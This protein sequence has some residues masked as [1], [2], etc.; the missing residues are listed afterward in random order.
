M[1]IWSYILFGVHYIM[2]P[3]STSRYDPQR[4]DPKRFIPKLKLSE[5][6]L[7]RTK[8]TRRSKSIHVVWM[9]PFLFRLRCDDD[10]SNSA[11]QQTA[12]PATYH[13]N[14]SATVALSFR[15]PE[16]HTLLQ[17]R[18]GGVMFVNK[19]P[20]IFEKCNSNYAHTYH[21]LLDIYLVVCDSI[22]SYTVGKHLQLSPQSSQNI[23]YIYFG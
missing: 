8:P 12:T 18:W 9:Y 20:R 7:N 13:Y 2:H 3:Q 21:R 6:N 22:N 14:S 10:P 23:N 11:C 15:P 1:Y 4:I 17:I 5:H 16:D 19:L